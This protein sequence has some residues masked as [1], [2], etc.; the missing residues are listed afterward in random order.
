MP[1]WKDMMMVR[2]ERGFQDPKSWQIE[3]GGR[4]GAQW[5]CKGV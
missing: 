4:R 3:L 1:T 2:F 5:A